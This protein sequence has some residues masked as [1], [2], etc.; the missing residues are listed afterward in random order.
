MVT[1]N[2]HGEKKAEG[3]EMAICTAWLPYQTKEF[4]EL[5]DGVE[6]HFWD[7]SEDFPSD[8]GNVRFLVPP[9]VPGADRVL[10]EVLPRLPSLDVL[11][12]L[13]SGYDYVLPH[14]ASLP[15]GVCVCTTRG[16][17]SG[18]TAELAVALL[19]ASSRGLD[20]FMRQQAAGQWQS[21]DFMTLLGKRVLV[22]GHGAVGAAVE[23]RLSPFGCEVVRVARTGRPSADGHVYGAVDMPEL[24]PT[25]DAVILC[26][27]LTDETRGIFGATYFA[28][29]KDGA[30]LVN[31]GR[32]E[33]VQT[34]ALISELG[35]GRLRAALD[36]TMPEPLPQDHL[37]WRLPGVLVT[38][39]TGAFTDGFHAASRD[40]VRHQLDRYVTG[41]TLA[42]VALK[43]EGYSE[44]VL[45][46]G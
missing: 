17:H 31:V 27:P 34:D 35:R 18:A 14:V 38:P 3:Q 25:V 36:V 1:G 22:Y 12:L 37:L 20:Q 33:L 30:V 39:H 32:G 21:G 5:P 42:N 40:F 4:P 13:S 11:Q 8:P 26:A 19:L 7:G 28:L 10:R 29:L 2:V 41:E 9:P 46:L 23:S 24:L 16:V 43:K 44:R 15:S 45:I 6:C